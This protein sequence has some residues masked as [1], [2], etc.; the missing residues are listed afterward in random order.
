[1][2]N[3]LINSFDFDLFKTQRILIN[4][5]EKMLRD[6]L[7]HRKISDAVAEDSDIHWGCNTT[8]GECIVIPIFDQ[9]GVHS[10][11]KYRRSPLTEEGPKYL[12]D[13]GSKTALYCLHKIRYE[14]KVLI[15]EGEFDALVAWS[16]NIPAVTSTG[17]ALSFQEEWIEHFFGKEVV[18][19]FDNDK[20]GGEGMVKVFDLIP[21]AKILFLPERQG[22][23]DIT[24]YVTSGGDL[25][26]LIKTA[27]GFEDIESIKENRAERISLYQST[28]FHDAYIKNHTK[29][30]AAQ[31]RAARKADDQDLIS[32]ARAYPITNIL[33]FKHNKTRCLWHNEKDA[34]LTYY[35]E[36]NSLYCFGGCGKSYDV[37][38]V[39][40]K[41]YGVSFREAVEKLQS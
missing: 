6:W 33:D 7:Y 32:R 41:K 8:M 15:V 13:H 27:R 35:P 4:M 24:D 30:I 18:I 22:V 1:M 39:F 19:C 14:K 34:S 36:S 5:Q 21:T 11:N 10:F 37:I 40:R 31:G 38:D 23:K 9:H 2:R 29:V 16:A 28:F 25:N 26:E 12:Y 20:A 17:G 3:V